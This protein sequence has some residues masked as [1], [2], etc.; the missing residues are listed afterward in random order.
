M[1]F[2]QPESHAAIIIRN[3]PY[4]R[5]SDHAITKTA[6]HRVGDIQIKKFIKLGN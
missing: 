1:L 6:A 4:C 5:Q 2:F 3:R